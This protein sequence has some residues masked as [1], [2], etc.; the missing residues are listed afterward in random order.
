VSAGRDILAATRLP[1][2]DSEIADCEGELRRTGP[3][4]APGTDLAAL[5]I[6]EQESCADTLE[7]AGRALKRLSELRRAKEGL[8]RVRGDYSRAFIEVTGPIHPPVKVEIG[9]AVQM[10]RKR[11]DRV[12]LILGHNKRIRVKEETPTRR[13]QRKTKTR[14]RG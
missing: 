11:L 7:K 6:G 2:I 13:A 3:L 14:R 5:S 1:E 8:E 12:V 9:P 10:F 4:P